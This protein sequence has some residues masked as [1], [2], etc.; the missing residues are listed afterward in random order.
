MINK[1][2]VFLNR[3]FKDSRE[4]LSSISEELLSKGYV[5][6]SFREGIMKREEEYPTAIQAENFS[7][8]I[9]HTDSEH[10]LKPGIAFVRLN[11]GCDFKEM[12]TNE[13]I[14]VNMAFV[15]LVKE[16]EKQVSL[17]T[18]L[19]GLFSNNDILE[20]LYKENDPSV[21][22]AMLNREIQ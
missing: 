4:L 12:C 9:P 13:D 3:D 14:K 16:K 20:K 15:L 11:N 22:E 17:L 19:M 1:D 18:K 7:L 6:D 21:I 2:I 5:K 10:I 8:A